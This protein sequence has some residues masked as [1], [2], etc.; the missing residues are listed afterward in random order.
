MNW[1]IHTH[2]RTHKTH[3]HTCA[4]TLSPL[5]THGVIAIHI[6][7][8][9]AVCP[10]LRTAYECNIKFNLG[11]GD[12]N[13]GAVQK[14]WWHFDYSN[15]TAPMK[16]YQLSICKTFSEVD[17]YKLLRCNLCTVSSLFN[18]EICLTSDWADFPRLGVKVISWCLLGAAISLIRFWII[19]DCAAAEQENKAL[20]HSRKTN[21]APSWEGLGRDL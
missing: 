18:R 21:W 3:S 16:K 9:K 1:V 2:S 20:F 10:K 12:A 15:P 13:C 7:Q 17:P 5:Q 8:P 14:C 11:G 19:P 4:H 6:W